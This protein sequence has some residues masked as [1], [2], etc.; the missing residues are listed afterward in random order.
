MEITKKNESQVYEHNSLTPNASE[1]MQKLSSS[2][3]KQ[4]IS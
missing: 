2:N 1:L 3:Y 4:L